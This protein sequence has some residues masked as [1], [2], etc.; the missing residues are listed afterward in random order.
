M[1]LLGFQSAITN[2]KRE[3]KKKNPIAIHKI[4]EGV[5]WIEQW[6]LPTVHN[7]EYW[8]STW[9]RGFEINQRI[10]WISIKAKLV[11]INLN[12]MRYKHGLCK[13]PWSQWNIKNS[14]TIQSY[15]ERCKCSYVTRKQWQ[16]SWLMTKIKSVSLSVDML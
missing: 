8:L 16:L 13:H 7:L 6:M 5:S 4:L 12:S 14:F 2:Y 15:S 10:A 1:T 3:T 11:S 9:W